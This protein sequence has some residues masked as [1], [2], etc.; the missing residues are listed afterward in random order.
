VL[1]E[2]PESFDAELIQE[3]REEAKKEV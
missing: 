1:L 2:E 3:E